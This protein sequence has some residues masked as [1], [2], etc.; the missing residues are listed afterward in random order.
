VTFPLP[1]ESIVC[2]LLA[3]LRAGMVLLLLPV[4]GGEGTPSPVRVLLSLLIGGLLVGLPPHPSAELPA[5]T[6]GLVLAAGRELLLGLS[7]GFLC[8]VLLAAPALAGDLAAEQLGLK[9]AE[10]VDPMTRVPNTAPSRLYESALLLAFLAL[11]GHHD[12]LRALHH[13]FDSFPVGRTTL[14]AGLPTIVGSLGLCLRFAVTIAAPLFAVLMVGSVSL[15][16]LARA[17][18]ELQVMTFGYPLRLLGVLL[19]ATALFPL[20]LRPGLRLFETLRNGLLA[21][22]GG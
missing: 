19:A 2:V 10:E 1:L 20:V 13:S 6:S 5:T 22:V 14:P 12:V 7:I 9:M 18:P 11:G 8:R 15:A 16:L 21:L 4:L 3:A 17:V